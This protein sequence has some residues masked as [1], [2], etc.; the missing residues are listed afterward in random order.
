M[1]A[2]IAGALVLV[3]L[4]ARGTTATLMT[5]ALLATATANSGPLLGSEMVLRSSARCCCSSTG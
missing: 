2:F 1:T 5:L 3:L 4:G